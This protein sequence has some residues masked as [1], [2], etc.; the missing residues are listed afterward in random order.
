MQNDKLLSKLIN[1]LNERA[2]ESKCLYEI[3]N[4]LNDKELT[5]DDV[6]YNI[7]TILPMGWQFPEICKAQLLYKNKIFQVEEFEETLWMQESQII[8]QGKVVG[9]I[10]IYYTEERPQTDIGPFLNEELALIETIGKQFEFYLLHQQLRTVFD[11]TANE[12][13]STQSEWRYILDLLTRTD[14]GFAARISRKMINFL[15]LNGV[16]EAESLLEKFSIHDEGDKEKNFP[17]K[18]L[19]DIDSMMTLKDVF[20]VAERHLNEKEILT[21]VHKW[22]KQE[23]SAFMANILNNNATTLSEIISAL[24]KYHFLAEQGLE[25]STLRQKSF[26]VALIRKIMSDQGSFIDVAKKHLDVCAFYKLTENLIHPEHSLGK[27]GGKSSG[28]IVASHILSAVSEKEKSLSKIKTPKTWYITADGILDFMKHNNLEDI[29]EQKYKDIGLVRQEYSYVIHVFKNSPL[30][31]DMIKDLSKCLDD[32]GNMPL[33]IRS[34]SLLED[35][36]GTAFAGKYKSLFVANQGSKKKRMTD[37]M[38][39]ITEVYASTFGPDP[40]QYRA[41]HELLDYN[42]QMGIMIQQV[43]GKK[44][45]DYFFPAFA[46][47]AFS[48][49]EYRWSSRIKRE[50]G[51]IR[52]VPGLGTRAVDRTSNDYPVLI[53]PKNPDLRVNVSIDE[54]IRYSPKQI[55]IINLKNNEFETKDI[56]EIIKECGDSYPMINK[57]VSIISEKYLHPAKKFGTDYKKDNF[58]V[59]FNGLFSDKKFMNEMNGIL[60]TLKQKYEHP[61]DIEFAHDGDDL[62][63]LQ[64]RPQNLGYESKPITF[65]ENVKTEDILFTANKFISNG[66]VQGISHVVYVD[67]IEY[68]NLSSLEEL[69]T[70]GKVV[71]LL[72]KILPKRQFILMG[73]GRWGSRGDIKLGVSVSYSDISNSSM[74]IEIAK[75]NRDYVPDLSFGTHF[76]L[77]LV[78]AGIRYLPLYPDNRDIVF[79]EEFF[80]ES[81]NVL[82]D[83]LPQYSS[84]C[85]VI[86][87]IDVKNVTKGREIQIFMSVESDKAMALIRNV[88]EESSSVYHD[89]IPAKKVKKRDIDQKDDFHWKWR[90]RAIEK[91]AEALDVKRFGVKELYIFGSAKNATSR[92][93]SDID[94]LIH[95]VGDE[96]Q[97]EGLLI[98]LD[99]WSTSLGYYNFLSTGYKVENILDIH[100]ITDDDI[101]NKDSYAMK[102][103]AVSDAARPLLI[104]KK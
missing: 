91:I 74:L 99:A 48:N 29:M 20:S 14:R 2:K 28:L 3:Q 42:E 1:D 36:L 21:N 8:L 6:C 33:V 77:D 87:V 62:Y 75:K 39:A 79:N 30:S 52:L 10:N 35:R 95:F 93:D 5:F 46:G 37:L 97:K 86:K 12:G 7:V 25:L 50:D 68:A 65:P 40:I 71:G 15:C 45:G 81:T 24:E 41:E 80:E 27:L 44:V 89:N 100:I 59:T 16:N 90:L 83:L 19:D 64:C 101:K 85:K 43:V 17:F 57:L 88:D 49:N 102:I 53:S 104:N 32:L 11:N 78:E 92:P 55:D 31:S 69:K 13:N 38:D 4:L 73:P 47:V 82:K 18:A 76:F 54:M 60:L 51:L 70:V 22:I 72:N 98:W 23:S 66:L 84:L 96:S 26:T 56:D 63:L 61:V 67:P 103:S 94:I 34:S 58:V 9:Q